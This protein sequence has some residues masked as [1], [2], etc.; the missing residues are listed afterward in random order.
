MATGSQI[1]PELPE[2]IS[3]VPRAYGADVEAVAAAVV[4]AVGAVVGVAVVVAVGMV[5]IVKDVKCVGATVGPV[6]GD[7]DGVRVEAVVALVGDCVEL[8]ETM[9]SDHPK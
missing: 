9:Y 7:I 2:S 6:V 8:G 5:D 1:E 3:G 4:D